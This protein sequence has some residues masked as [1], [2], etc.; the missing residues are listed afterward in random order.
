[1]D[2]APAP[3]SRYAIRSIPTLTLLHRGREIA[4]TAGAMA[5]GDLEQWVARQQAA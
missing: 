5:A 4:R 2:D 3:A 1:M